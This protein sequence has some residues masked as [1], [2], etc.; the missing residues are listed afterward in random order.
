MDAGLAGLLGGVIGAAVGGL[1]TTAGAYV[2][3]HKAERQARLQVEAQ[4]QQQ[5]EQHRAEYLRDRR[6]PRA[7]AYTNFL[8]G[9]D[10]LRTILQSAFAEGRDN[11][12]HVRNSYQQAKVQIRELRALEARVRIEGPDLMIVPV[13]KITTAIALVISAFSA[14]LEKVPAAEGHFVRMARHAL[15]DEGDELHRHGWS[16]D[17]WP[18]RHNPDWA[19]SG[20]RTSNNVPNVPE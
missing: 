3:G 19:L 13:H 20:D 15:Q 11:P 10:E 14:L 7:Q 8:T 1:F 6:E 5:R 12:E 9:I 18:N 2:T 16:Y 17:P 4:H